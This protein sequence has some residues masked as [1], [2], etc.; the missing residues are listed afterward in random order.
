MN[1]YTYLNLVMLYNI[2][3]ILYMIKQLVSNKIKQKIKNTFKL[4]FLKIIIN[5]F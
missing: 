5:Y 3:Y 4:L 1:I 2:K